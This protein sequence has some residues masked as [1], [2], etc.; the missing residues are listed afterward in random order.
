MDNFLPVSFGN[1]YDP[2]L[3]GYDTTKK[4]NVEW[5]GWHQSTATKIAWRNWTNDWNYRERV[6]RCPTI[7]AQPINRTYQPRIAPFLQT[8][9]QWYNAL[10]ADE[11]YLFGGWKNGWET[12]FNNNYR[13]FPN[14]NSYYGTTNDPAWSNNYQPIGYNAAKTGGIRNVRDVNRLRLCQNRREG[15]D[16]PVETGV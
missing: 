4:A 3:P 8:V 10:P 7:S 14:G 16:V 11:K 1:W 12:S 2:S 13:Y 15:F 5:Y 6:G 9:V